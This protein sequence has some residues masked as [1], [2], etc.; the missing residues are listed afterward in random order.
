MQK[1]ILLL[2]ILIPATTAAQ[3]VTEPQIPGV[4]VDIEMDGARGII[5]DDDYGNII[6][7]VIPTPQFALNSILEQKEWGKESARNLLRQL[8]GPYPAAELDAFADDLGRLILESPSR[9][10]ARKALSVIGDATY[11]G[12]ANNAVPY[13][14]GID[15]LIKIYETMDGSE[16]ISTDHVLD[17][18]LYGGGVQGVTYGK[19]L[20]ALSE[21]P[22]K[23]CWL[24]P[25]MYPGDRASEL[26]PKEEICPYE[27]IRWCDLGIKLGYMEQQGYDTGIDL[28]FIYSICDRGLSKGNCKGPD[29][30]W[31]RMNYGTLPPREQ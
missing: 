16:A 27:G 24:A 17:E 18:I 8:Y 1:L 9:D 11:M 22:E 21:Q 4:I 10:V 31:T 12:T 6:G 19:G 13:E 26:P 30:V 14:R 28:A 23:P 2:T 3:K 29:C 20:F 15:L 5:V 7:M 25:Y